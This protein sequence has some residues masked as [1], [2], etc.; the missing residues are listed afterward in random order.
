MGESETPR[1]KVLEK[2]AMA[3]CCNSSVLH[4]HLDLDVLDPVE[5]PHVIPGVEM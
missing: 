2:M 3:T 5:F 4:I 1:Q